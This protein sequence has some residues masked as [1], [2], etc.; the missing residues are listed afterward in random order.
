MAAPMEQMTAARVALDRWVREELEAGKPRG[1]D[2]V[3]RVTELFRQ[4]EYREVADE[5]IF[6][7]ILQILSRAQQEI[8]TQIAVSEPSAGP[9]FDLSAECFRCLR[10]A[11]AQCLPN[12]DT[13]RNI[14]LIEKAITL[15]GVFITSNT[16][17]ESCLVAFRCS[18]QF[19]GN[20]AGG[21]RDSQN[22]IWKRAFPHL[23]LSCLSHDDDKVFAYGSM[24]LYTCMDEDKIADL[25]EPA[26]LPLALGVVS[27]YSTRSDAEWLHLIV[28]D[29]FLRCPELVK[30]MYASHSH[31]DRIT[32]LELI[33]SKV[34][35]KTPLTETELTSLREIAEFLSDCFQKQCRAVLKLAAPGD[36]EEEEASVVIRLLDLLCEMTSDADHLSCLQC[37]PGLLDTVVDTLRL[38]HLA[39]KQSKNVFTSTHSASL[40]SDLTHVAVGFKAHLIRL[41]AN[42]CYK[43][44]ENQ[45]KIFHLDGIPLILD[46]CSIDDNNPFLNQW[47]IYA[48]RNLTEFNDK[49]QELIASMERQGLADTSLLKSMGLHVEERDG[50]LLLKSVKKT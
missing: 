8:Q 34:N 42:L 30:Q 39:G 50:K 19:L 20:V 22:S 49:N 7:L 14:G 44:R 31:A 9:W 2:G 37:C 32:L 1:E 40:G 12:Q 29:R 46:S 16:S 24:V 10:N 3:R 4:A 33:L 11:S 36:C 17:Q 35:E 41:I 45:D 15:I 23:F 28:T 43:N 38:T 25:L 48:I 13:I 5:K 47:A 21:N 6:T 18:L 27:A 26:N